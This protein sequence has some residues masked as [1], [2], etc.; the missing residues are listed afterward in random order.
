MFGY[1]FFLSS[2]VVFLVKEKESKVSYIVFLRG[3]LYK[4]LQCCVVN[5]ISSVW[6]IAK[7]YLWIEFIKTII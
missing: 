7:V 4:E 3:N 6:Y 1:S 2:Y 5:F